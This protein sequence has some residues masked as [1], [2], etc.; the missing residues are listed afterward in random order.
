MAEERLNSSPITTEHEI[1]RAENLRVVFDTIYG[2]VKALDGV[3]L[4]MKKKE[5]L[6]LVGESGSGKSVLGLSIIG[7]LPIPP[8]RILDGSRVYFQNRNL[9]ALRGKEMQEV[10]GTGITMIFQEPLTSL[11]PVLKVGDQI[12]ES[13]RVRLSREVGD[14]SEGERQGRVRGMKGVEDEAIEALKLVRIPTP[15]SVIHSYPHQ[16]S[17]GMRQRVMIAM[18]LAAKP[19]LIIADEPTTA[20]DVTTQAQILQLMRDL[21]EEVQTSVIFITHDLGVVAEIA[22]D[23]AVMYAGNIVERAGVY[24]LFDDPVHPYTEALLASLPSLG[25]GKRHRI[26]MIPGEVPSLISPPS[27]CPFHPRCKYAFDRCSKTVPT[28][29]EIKPGREVACLLHEE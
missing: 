19:S 3:N 18:A 25:A 22:S 4:T 2:T 23:V 24:D 16:L 7:L 29:K 27:G 10:R 17:G 1:V 9:L 15:N 6:G 14:G 12:A 11:N 20:L 26:G 21:M 5:V 28:L 8:G 13:I